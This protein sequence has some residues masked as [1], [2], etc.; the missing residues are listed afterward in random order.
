MRAQCSHHGNGDTEGRDAM[1]RDYPMLCSC[2]VIEAKLK[3]VY[4][5][6]KNHVISHQETSSKSTMR[7]HFI[8]PLDA[9]DQEDGH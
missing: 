2:Y 9:Y 3:S 7:K 5:W 4:R 6:V 8:S 1:G